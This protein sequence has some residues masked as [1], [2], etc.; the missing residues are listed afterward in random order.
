ML[1]CSHGCEINDC[2]VVLV[3]CVH[4]GSRQNVSCTIVC[5]LDVSDVGCEL[6]DEVQVMY[7]VRVE[8]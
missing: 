2:V 7:G 1:S 5:F 8:K 4:F 6:G 3:H